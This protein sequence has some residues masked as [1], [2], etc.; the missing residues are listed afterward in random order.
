MALSLKPER[1][2]RYKDVVA[3]LIKYGRSDLVQQADLGVGLIERER[4]L[5]PTAE[6][7]AEELAADLEKLGPTFIKLG[8]LLSTR[9]DLLPEPYLEALARLQDN[10][11]PF[12]PAEVEQIV[13]SELGGRISKLFAEFERDPTAAASLAQV[14]R[15]RMRDGRAVVVK[16][17]RP[18]VREIIVEDL[19]ALEEV[20]EFID[21]HTEIGKRYEFSNMLEDLRASLLRELDFKREANN[22]TRLRTSLRE[23][24]HI[25]IPEPIDDFTTSRVLTMEYIPGKK[26]TALS[27]LRLMELDGP[28]LSEEIFRAYLKQILVDGFF[29]ADPHPG[30]VFVTDDNRLALL[31][32][33]MVGHISGTFQENL[34]RLLLAISEG[35]GDE[36]AEGAMKMGEPKPKFDKK[37]Y[38][39]R[40]A[41]L[42]AEYAAATAKNIDAGHVVLEIMRISADCWFRLPPEFTVIAK[43]MLNLDRV[44]YVLY[45]DFDPNAVIREEATNLLTRR[46]VKSI[47]PGSILTRVIEVKEFVER[48]PTRV[49][50]ILDAIGN[51]E[52]KIGVDAID[53]RIVL[54]G[55]QKVANRIALG[56]I[57]AALIVGAA[58]MM[59]VE[60]SFQILGYPGLPMIFFMLAAIAGLILVASI[61]FYDKHPRKKS[62]GEN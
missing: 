1:I 51:N 16:V 48:L 21:A 29:H 61:V 28:A 60:T 18:G 26:I 25:V 5:D 23:F 62:D 24:E 8:Q 45:P 47:E 35:R 9:G 50:K 56:L 33:G 31:D 20:A 32:L 3:L 15:A 34:L 7:K 39:H 59:R 53:E 55:L 41:N 17:Q 10:V 6:P 13:E 14:H 49:N 52:L 19:E 57:L 27:P 38:E 22:L 40:V 4:A 11:E 42:V 36:A 46:I 37:D 30:N 43:A 2:K 54:D 12:S 58:L 44:V